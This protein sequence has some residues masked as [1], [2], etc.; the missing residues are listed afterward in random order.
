M[1]TVHIDKVTEGQK[2][3]NRADNYLW[4]DN[5]C[6]ICDKCICI[7]L[8]LRYNISMSAN[9]NKREHKTYLKK[10]PSPSY[11]KN[12]RKQIISINL[13]MHIYNFLSFWC[14]FGS[15]MCYKQDNESAPPPTYLIF[16]Y[17]VLPIT[18]VCEYAYYYIQYTYMLRWV[19]ILIW[20]TRETKGIIPGHGLI[21]NSPVWGLRVGCW[22]YQTSE[23]GVQF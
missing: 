22:R 7:K 18:S 8:T 19:S 13:F 6:V 17:D 2:D 15:Q 14:Y 4:F 11:T 21:H 16:L 12:K 5:I 10:N 3:L 20:G 1:G 23:F 9:M